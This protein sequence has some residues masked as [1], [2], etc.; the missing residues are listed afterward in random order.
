MKLAAGLILLT[1]VLAFAGYQLAYG[2]G[3]P[4]HGHEPG[5][6]W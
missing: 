1:I 5:S 4:E 3:K 2:G 6:Y